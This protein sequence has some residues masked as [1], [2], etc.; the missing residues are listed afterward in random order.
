MRIKVRLAS[1]GFAAFFA[2]SLIFPRPAAAGSVLVLS[3]IHFN[4][5]ADTTLVDG[6]ATTEPR[7]WASILANSTT[8]MSG[9]GAD[10]D[11]NL[12]QSALTAMA[13]QP[14][15]DAV[16]IPGDF[17]AHRFRALF[18]ASAT[19]RSNAAYRAF[20]LKTMRFL[21][22]ELEAHF[23]KTPIL[24]ALGNNDSFC[25]DYELRPGG[26]FLAGT[27]GIVARMIGPEAGDAFRRSWQALG[28]YVVA[29]PVVKGARIIV[30]NTNFF[31]PHYKDACGTPADGNP[32]AATLAWL[33]TA[34]ADAAA[35]HRRVWLAYHIPPGADA[36]STSR[37][38]SCPL[39]PVPMFAAPYARAFQQLMVRYRK[40][41]IVSFA[42]HVHMDGFRLLRDHGKVFGVVMVD[43]A[44]SP[45]FGQN[46][47]FRR[48]TV[49]ADGT[50]ADQSVY[51]LAD[52]RAAVR[53]APAQWRREMD[54]DAAW[55]LPRFDAQSLDALYRR[56]SRSA[57]AWARWR[58]AYAVQGPARKV[59]N[60]AN[61][62]I[63]RCT[64][65]YG[66]TA[67][68]ARCSCEDAAP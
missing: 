56:I 45:I 64:A 4:P 34:L 19:D 32:A 17:L 23:P 48:V 31:S 10:T 29:N 33:K 42:G 30:I 55:H 51:D 57:A 65:G 60:S 11:W 8:R 7:H 53:G 21:A 13:A 38:A 44:L 52:L 35:A 14:K 12:L 27:A 20:V 6:L 9:Y 24:P 26:A 25:G 22:L 39:F 50:I 16:L 61:A 41:V 63:Y 47:S 28:N 2:L 66:Q 3:D 40:T 58:D 18:D 49:A 5:F 43:P 36:Y 54:F 15:P 37:H 59:I 62:A 46:P 1:I 67:E 68:V